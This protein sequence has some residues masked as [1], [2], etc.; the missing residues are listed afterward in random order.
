MSSTKKVILP[1][2]ILNASPLNASFTSKATN[3]QYLENISYQLNVITSANTGLFS[4]QVS[5]D[6]NTWDTLTT[7]PPIPALANTN[8]IITISLNQLPYTWIRLAFTIGTGTNGS[9]TAFITG[10][11]L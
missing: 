6:G 7:T 4:V 3:I 11:E 5:I 9:V 2:A 1:Y 8:T 10:K